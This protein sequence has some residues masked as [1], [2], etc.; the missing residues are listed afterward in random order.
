MLRTRWNNWRLRRQRR[1]LD[2]EQSCVWKKAKKE[3]TESER[4]T[5]TDEWYG[6]RGWEFDVIDAQIRHNDSRDLLERAERLYLPVPGVN[7]T[8]KWLPEEEQYGW[9]A[10]T[11]AAMTELATAINTK[12]RERR[13]VWEW[14][15]KILSACIAGLTGLVGAIT[16][17]RAVWTK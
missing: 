5:I 6:S 12:E 8:D 1:E 14:R 16:G 9:S 4:N 17:L 15:A 13:E 3:K 10:L 2:K 7:D 11:P